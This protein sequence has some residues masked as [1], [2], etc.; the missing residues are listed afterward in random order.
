MQGEVDDIVYT[1]SSPLLHDTLCAG[2]IYHSL[3][4]PWYNQSSTQPYHLFQTMHT[5]QPVYF[6]ASQVFQ[7]TLN[8]MVWSNVNHACD[9]TRIQYSW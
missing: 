6:G 8:L 4:I 1:V 5:L 9:V 2:L 7:N 3:L